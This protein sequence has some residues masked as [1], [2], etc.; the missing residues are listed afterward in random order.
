MNAHESNTDN[1]S[2]TCTL[3]QEVV[4]ELIGNYIAHFTR[5]LKDLTRLIEE[6]STA[7]PPN[8]CPR[9]RSGTTSSAG[10]PVPDTHCCNVSLIAVFPFSS[11][12]P[13]KNN[14]S[15]PYLF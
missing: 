8:L 2:E 9:T 3:T 4:H 11:S 6:I 13:Q 15:K 10:G 5:Q 12:Y 1:D 7:H 14:D